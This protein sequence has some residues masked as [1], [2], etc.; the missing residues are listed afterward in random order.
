MREEFVSDLVEGMVTAKSI[1]T[2]DGL[3][4]VPKNVT[5]TAPI[6]R[7]LDALGIFSIAVEDKLSSPQEDEPVSEIEKTPEF[8]AFKK[9]YIEDKNRLNDA[10]NQVLDRKMKKEDISTLIE[11]SWNTCHQATNSY[12]TINMI[13]SMH[14]YSDSTYMHSMNVGII[15]SLIGKWLGWSEAEQRLLHTCGLFH[16]IGKLAIP[17]TILDKPGKLTDEEYNTI[18]IHTVTGYH[19]LRGISGSDFIATAAKYHHERYDGKGYPN[20]L[21]GENIPEVAR[22]LGVADSYDAMSSNRSYRQAL[23]QEIVRAE[24]LKCKGTQFDPVIADVMLELI[25]EDKE[26]TMKQDDSM[27]R[28]ILI[29][30]DEAINHKLI[31]HIMREEPM[32]Q[33]SSALTG[34][35]ALE[36][37]EENEYDLIMLDVMM[38]G[39]SGLET[40]KFIRKKTITPVVLMTGDKTLDTSKGFAELGCDDYITKPF[41]PLLIKEVVHNM[42]ERIQVTD[43]K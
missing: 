42:T 19:I 28:S 17:K 41:L 39:M 32:Y 5:L 15:A 31:A 24:I 22:I 3:L 13:Y 4:V 23:P 11:E 36:L 16:D 20:G 40:L 7:H 25:D 14:S 9:S 30:D 33:I 18:K 43:E 1:Y 21:K 8:K 6:I 27:N 37:L 12:D 10:F 34:E 26:Y 35:K 29:V 38:P 2:S